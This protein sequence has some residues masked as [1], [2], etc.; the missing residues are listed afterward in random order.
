MK[1]LNKI[2]IS[3]SLVFAIAII[4]LPIITK[5]TNAYYSGSAQMMNNQN[6]SNEDWG[7]MRTMHDLMWKDSDLTQKEFEQLIKTQKE[8]MNWSWI[9]KDYKTVEEYNKFR[10][11]GNSNRGYNQ[12]SRFKGGF[13]CPM[14]N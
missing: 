3:V 14:W 1:N 13:N 9:E 5:T 6:I 4:A 2:I 8:F 10:S 7:D 11:D 12:G